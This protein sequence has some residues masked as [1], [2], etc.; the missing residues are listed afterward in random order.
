MPVKPLPR[1][2]YALEE[3]TSAQNLRLLQASPHLD[4]LAGLMVIVRRSL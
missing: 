2:R 1:V 3:I 4:R